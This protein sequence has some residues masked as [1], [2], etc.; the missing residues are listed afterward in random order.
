MG[1]V[2]W[3]FQYFR[4]YVLVDYIF[5]YFI[6]IS[7]LGKRVGRS[8][9]IPNIKEIIEQMDSRTVAVSPLPYNVTIEDIESFFNEHGKVGSNSYYINYIYNRSHGSSEIISSS[10]FA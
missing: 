3:W 2:I 7:L 5:S 6:D 10:R 9:E 4:V 1:L 8:T